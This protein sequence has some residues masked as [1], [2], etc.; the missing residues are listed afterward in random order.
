MW[1]DHRWGGKLKSFMGKENLLY[2]FFRYYCQRHGGF[3]PS[4]VRLFV[5]L[6][7]GEHKNCWTE[8]HQTWTE[9]ESQ[10]R[11]EPINFWF[12]SRQR[13][14]YVLLPL[15]HW[16]HFCPSFF[17]SQWRE[18]WCCSVTSECVHL[19]LSCLPEQTVAFLFRWGGQDKLPAAVLR[20]FL[21]RFCSFLP[22]LICVDSLR[23]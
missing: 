10:P 4:R 2:L 15:W 7:A 21:F 9:D 5:G 13:G 22:H 12:G 18:L 3:I 1:F 16:N 14:A 19:P 8:F 17:P 20:W 11:T 23:P 6:S